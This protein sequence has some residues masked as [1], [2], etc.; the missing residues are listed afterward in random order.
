[1]SVLCGKRI[2]VHKYSIKIPLI[3][4]AST[5]KIPFI[6]TTYE[7]NHIPYELIIIANV[8]THFIED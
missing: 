6:I 4:Q 8:N 5:Q 7:H 1:M 2:L 3:H